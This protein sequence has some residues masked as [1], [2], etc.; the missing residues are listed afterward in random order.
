MFM[1]KT[2]FSSPEQLDSQDERI[3]Y[4]CSVIIFVVIVVV[5]HNVQTSS[6]KSL[7]QSKPNFM[8]SILRRGNQSL[9]ELSRSHDQD[10]RHA[11]K[12]VKT[13]TNLLISM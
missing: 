10:G 5:V 8:W 12:L 9:Y 3:V 2:F 13:L 6:L 1:R 11:H 4:P 7:G